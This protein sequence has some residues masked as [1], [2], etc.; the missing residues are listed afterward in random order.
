VRGAG[1]AR[2][3]AGKFGS[4]EMSLPS[5][6]VSDVKRS[7]VRCMSLPESPAVPIGRPRRSHDV[8][9]DVEVGEVHLGFGAATSV[10]AGWQTLHTIWKQ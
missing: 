7:P 8:V 10:H 4:V 2:I 5:C 6:A 3:S 9:L 1:G